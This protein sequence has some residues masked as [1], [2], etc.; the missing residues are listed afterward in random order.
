MRNGINYLIIML[1]STHNEA[2]LFVCQSN[3]ARTDASEKLCT[4]HMTYH[5]ILPGREEL[6]A[7]PF[8]DLRPHLCFCLFNI[9]DPVDINN[10]TKSLGMF[11]KFCQL[12]QN[13]TVAHKITY[14]YT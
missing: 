8:G 11:K 9:E 7:S 6:H 10:A 3:L 14:M 13:S 1:L 4:S 5:M 2:N 12:C